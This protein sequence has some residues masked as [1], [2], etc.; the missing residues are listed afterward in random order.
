MIGSR[1]SV[2]LRA[3]EQSVG[4]QAVAVLLRYPDADL[5]ASL[6]LVSEAAATLPP[7]VA[8]PLTRLCNHLQA[9]ALEDLQAHY[10]DTFDLRRRC[11]LY[12]TYFSHGD[13]RKRGMALLRFSHTYRAAGVEF[14]GGDLPDHVAVVC[15]FAATV[16]PVQG[17][18]LLTEHRAGLEVLRTALVDV[19]SPYSW[20]VDALCALLPAASARDLDKARELARS[21]PPEEEVGL[22]PYGPPETTG[23]RR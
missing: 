14:L 5:L 4:L 19:G 22:E 23:V 15:E 16:D 12:L 17:M 21:G 9:T 3:R 10:V 13:T 1:R 6:D 20:V 8:D 11:C 7:A 18:R 2:E